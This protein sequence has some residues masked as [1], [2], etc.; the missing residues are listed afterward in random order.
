MPKGGGNRKPTR[1]HILHGTGRAKRLN[2]NEPKPRP[3]A[4]TCPKWLPKEAKEEWSRLAAELDALGLLTVLDRAA[5]AAYCVAVARFREASAVLAR[6]GNVV[7]G[8]RGVLRKHPMVTVLR[9]SLDLLRAFAQEFGL[10]PAARTRIEVPERPD[11][12]DAM[13]KLLD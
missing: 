6:E 4:P 13:E 11:A 10:T 2:K 7:P 12:D 3:V 8:H 9:Q 5:F 1:L